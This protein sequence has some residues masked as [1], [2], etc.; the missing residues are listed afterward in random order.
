MPQELLS[1]AEIGR[2][3]NVGRERARQAAASDP[4][5]PAPRPLE[6]ASDLH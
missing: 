4:T 2:Y 1:L 3:L 5:F 6:K